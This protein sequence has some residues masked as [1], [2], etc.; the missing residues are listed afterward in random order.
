MSLAQSVTFDA[1]VAQI[2]ATNLRSFT[3]SKWLKV[4]QKNSLM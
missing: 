4:T 1:G 3:V 2:E